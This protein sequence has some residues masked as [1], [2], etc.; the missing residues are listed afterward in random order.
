MLMA[1]SSAPSARQP[2]NRKRKA[3]AKVE[4]RPKVIEKAI[5]KASAG[6]S[7]RTSKILEDLEEQYRQYTLEGRLSECLINL[8]AATER[9][10]SIRSFQSE[11]SNV[12]G[13]QL[14]EMVGD[15]GLAL[16]SPLDLEAFQPLEQPVDV[17]P[18]DK[19]VEPIHY[20]VDLAPESQS[21]LS[22]CP[23]ILTPN[24][25]QQLVD[26]GLPSSVRTMTWHRAYALARDGD[27]F[28]AMLDH[29]HDYKHTI[30]VAETT[31]GHIL[32]GFA[33]APWDRQTGCARSFYGNGQS[34]L[35]ST[36][37]ADPAR[38]EHEDDDD[39]LFIYK[40]TGYNTYCQVCD[41]D[42][43]QLAMGG[44]GSFGL[45]I[46]DNFSCGSSGSCGTFGNPPLVPEP[47]GTFEIVNFEVYGFASMAEK[48]GH[49]SPEVQ[50]RKTQ[51]PS[52]LHMDSP[53]NA[54]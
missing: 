10:E 18:P 37:P 11:H 22:S 32:G 1:N 36:H 9:S 43:G 54:G 21:V 42:D 38:D 12:N 17:V 31:R 2:V 30:I 25:I 15:V 6:L 44:G 34:F 20:P 3:A 48:Y 4:H 14:R 49:V 40:W 16:F 41:V 52:L 53:L 23:H 33:A 51:K 28:V 8:R 35:F 50:E 26:E 45:I 39:K 47:G 29:C 13:T 5:V 7:E 46:D 27:S 19:P 24:M